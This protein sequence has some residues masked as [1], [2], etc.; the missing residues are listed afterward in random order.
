MA[1]NVT[2]RFNID[3]LTRSVTAETF[4]A[5]WPFLVWASSE[6]LMFNSSIPLFLLCREARQ[7]GAKV[8]LS[9]EGADE[10][11]AGYHHYPDYADL[12]DDG[13]AGYLLR[14]NFEINS[15][16]FVLSNWI[17]DAEWGRRQWELLKERLDQALP[18]RN[19]NGGLA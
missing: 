12:D 16:D 11:F 9:G 19:R 18:F 14:H 7:R 10:L 17:A 15:P 8:M 13:T 4:L 6:P 5:V 3:L 2:R 1:D